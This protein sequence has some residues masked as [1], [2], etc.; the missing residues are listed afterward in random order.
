MTATT[1]TTRTASTDLTVAH[2][3]QEQLGGRMFAM[4][5]GAKDFMGGD[6]FLQFSIPASRGKAPGKVNKCRVTLAGDDTYT[7]TFYYYNRR[8]F[9]CPVVCSESGIYA[10]VL[11][12]YFTEVTGLYTTLR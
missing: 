7:V 1:S 12:D 8:T 2:T 3:I 11:A 4:M 5:T 6:N 10:D 9:D